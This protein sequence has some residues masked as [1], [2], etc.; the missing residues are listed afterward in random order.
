MYWYAMVLRVVQWF[1]SYCLLRTFSTRS[2]LSDG[3][4][5]ASETVYII[6]YAQHF[7]MLDLV[8]DKI[9]IL[10]CCTLFHCGHIKSLWIQ[11]I[12]LFIFFR[13]TLLALLQS[14]ACPSASDAKNHELC[15]ILGM[16]CLH[17]RRNI[18][19]CLGGKLWYLQHNCV[20]DTTVYH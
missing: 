15:I 3:H 11:V 20:G 17:M 2:L 5:H 4:Y 9:C 13:V 14:Y 6:K 19:R 7:I 1:L 12:H 8:V 10:F 18:Y 16:H